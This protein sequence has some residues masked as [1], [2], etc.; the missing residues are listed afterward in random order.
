MRIKS[1]N[2]LVVAPASSSI[3][4]PAKK[5]TFHVNN[6][7]RIFPAIHELQPGAI[8]LDYAFIG[9][10]TEKILRRLTGNAFYSKIKIYCY[11]L[12]PH[13]KEDGLLQAL[14]VQHFIYAVDEKQTKQPH[15]KVKS[16][17]KILEGAVTK[18]LV[19]PS[20]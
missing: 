3:P 6:V 9:T 10:D 4:F 2:I 1:D 8:V 7:S 19:D 17:S 14:G 12:R 16:L 11:K 18:S 13:T 20:Y 5:Q 15:E